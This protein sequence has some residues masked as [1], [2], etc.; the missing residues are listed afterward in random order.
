MIYSM[1]AFGRSQKRSD[2]GLA[3]WELRSINHRYLEMSIRLPEMLRDLEPNIREIIH[4]YLHRGKIEC[5]L[6][7]LPG[8]QL[9]SLVT[10]NHNLLDQITK[11]ANSIRIQFPETIT[12]LNLIDLLAWNGVVVE[13]PF[14]IDL[15][16]DELLQLF[17][18]AIKDLKEGRQRE[19]NVLAQIIL[20][21]LERIRHQVEEISKQLPRIIERQ[22]D[23]ILQRLEEIKT[24][25][26]NQRLEQEMVFYCQKIDVAEE[27][28][29]LLTHIEEVKRTLSKGNSV[30]R[31]LDFMMQELN[32]EAN[33]LASKSNDT[34]VTHAAVEVKVLIEQIREQVQNIE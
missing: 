21:R 31:R 23:K 10:V 8:P 19:G 7:F 18:E 33:T 20:D 3:G 14:D 28:D 2:W 12:R 22:R 13:E 17:E 15:V 34:Q 11:M 24:S 4:D 1:T 26:D 6:R 30:G 9:G 25:L 29:R 27:I 32:R 16:R 5:N